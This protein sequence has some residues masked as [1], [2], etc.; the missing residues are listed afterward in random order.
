MPTY[1]Q[2]PE[3]ALKRANEFIDVGKKEPALEV[4]CDVI[5]SKRHR[6]W[7][8]IHEPIMEKY[9][10]LCVELRKSHVAKEGLYQYKIISQ[11]V[12]V[13]S[14]EDVV[15]KYLQ[16]AEE[17]TEAA[18]KESE[19]TVVDIDDLDNVNTPEDLLLSAV[20][21][22]DVQ[23]RTDRVVLIPWVK[24]LWESYRQCL[25]LLRNNNRLENLYQDVAYGAF[26]FCQKYQRKTEFRK[27]CDNLRNHLALIQKHQNQPLSINLSSPES[28]QIHLDTRLFQLETAIHMELWQEAYKAVEDIHNL[29]DISKKTPKA[30]LMATYY[31]KLGLV[32]W[33]SGNRLFHACALHRLLQL[34]REHR[35][36]LTAEEMQRM[37]SR[38]L[39]ATLA[40]PICPPRNDIGDMLDMGNT[41]V[42]NER[43]L[44]KMLG[45][46]TPPNR[47][48]L[49][50]DLI[51]YNVVPYVLPELR[52]LFN[53]LEVEFHPLMLCNRVNGVLNFL[54]GSDI[55]L[56]QYIPSLQTNALVRL[57]KQIAQ[58]YDTIS[59]SR[60]MGLVPFCTPFQI[61]KTIVESARNGAV[62]V[63]LDH[64]QQMLVFGGELSV[65]QTGDQQDGGPLVQEM[66]SEQIR[67]QLTEMS[68]A[69][70]HALQLI[71]PTQL[72]E[73]KKNQKQ[74]I[75][76]S[77]RRSAAK[78]H[79]RIL[80]RKQI[81][82]DR[83][84]RL[85]SI[86]VQREREEQDQLEEQQR[87]QREAEQQ[88]L[89]REAEDRARRKRQE[90]L[91][92]IQRKHAKERIKT[93]KQS[94][95]APKM[96]SKYT[97]EELEKLD[98]DEIMAK[99]VEQLE[100]EK[101]EL[102][103]RLKSQEKK[104]DYF[105]RAQR[106][107]EIP[108]LLK[109]YEEEAKASKDLWEEME[110]ERI[111]MAKKERE[112]AL[113]I[114]DR[115]KRMTK[116]KNEFLNMLKETRANIYNE[117][118][119]KFE[120][121]I[122][123]ARARRL[124]ER[125]QKRKH[126]RRMKW[127]A[128]KEEAEQQRRDEEAKR[129]REL[130]QQKEEEEYQERLR[131]LKEQEEKQAA[132]MRE[133]EEKMEKERARNDPRNRD[134]V[135]ENWRRGDDRMGDRR[136]DRPESSRPWRPRSIQ[137]GGW[138][139]RHQDSGGPPRGDHDDSWRRD[140]PPREEWRRDRPPRDD[141]R[142]PYDGG[143]GEP[144]RE[145]QRPPREITRP[146]RD[147]LQRPP[148]DDVQ[149][150]LRD[151]MQRP[152]RDDMQRPL[153]D[154]MQRPP[155]EDMQRPPRDDV[156]RPPRDEM[157]RPTRD[158]MQRAP[159]D[160]APRQ[161]PP[162]PREDGGPEVTT[163]DERPADMPPPV[164]AQEKQTVP[165]RSPIVSRMSRMAHDIRKDEPDFGREREARR[166][167][168]RDRDEQEN[169]ARRAN[170]DMPP[171]DDYGRDDR[172]DFRAGWG[173]DRDYGR[174][175]RDF[176]RDRGGFGRSDRDYRRDDWGR[177][178]DDRGPP[179]ER[180]GWRDDGPRDSP[181]R[182]GRD[183]QDNWRGGD[184]DQ[185]RGFRDRDGPRGPPRD[186][187]A[188]RSDRGGRDDRGPRRDD[189]RDRDDGRGRDDRR[190]RDGGRDWRREEGGGPGRDRGPPRDRDAG[191]KDRDGPRREIPKREVEP[192]EGGRAQRSN[193]PQETDEDG[194]TTVRR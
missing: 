141:I 39:L 30:Q 34:S 107:E 53:W 21:G 138:R 17:K 159:R 170:R 157:D 98:A 92:E 5:K 95:V 91:E 49:I 55:D 56:A 22:E 63:R 44:A 23:A 175:D 79:Q 115:L 130:K 179:R 171:R 162:G 20:S 194:W 72:L 160:E 187:D 158:E 82:E 76:Q 152:L 80:L 85:E 180:R 24:F 65:S 59:F 129:E 94:S 121:M 172:R 25:D 163:N 188:W 87:V 155:R 151:D 185:P 67:K 6:T 78:D 66:P 173:R 135:E 89:T 47:A 191:W 190:E 118:L 123:D 74:Q 103:A 104:I 156:Q 61:E 64:S 73:E 177:G 153:R 174:D 19:Q 192:E 178:G 71:R 10:A 119:S 50:N 161:E 83:K 148:R 62:Q 127:L 9:L 140:G 43:K 124:M 143:R 116:D 1:F 33:K 13:K 57:L 105:C 166:K 146:P 54:E 154:D 75:I 84:E 149:R 139:S 131:K 14:L 181:R 114:R 169:E 16:L 68:K 137:E 168:A 37:S 167:E 12:N 4:L 97:E 132:K 136:D 165:E 184:R 2:R 102:Q 142:G 90:E 128:E 38:V 15:R 183:D 48:Q 31:T 45:L 144:P 147:E 70:H 27:L 193:P 11:Q 133:V 41:A 134:T 164:S 110:S 189:R 40:V 96:F 7:Q 8:K 126:E 109:Q 35:K 122:K 60:I 88:R 182:D 28:Q 106:V 108:L 32:F 125:K 29:M 18:R 51:K 42:D 77:Y 93:L 46:Q 120:E 186:R 3:N 52:E 100:A 58:M 99:H 36:N 113:A 101:K 176:R 69:L 117:K 112:Q 86:T 145:I 111:E 26:K 150:P 81:I